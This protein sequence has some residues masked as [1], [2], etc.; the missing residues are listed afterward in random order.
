LGVETDLSSIMELGTS[1]LPS[2]WSSWGDSTVYAE[3]RFFSLARMPS[4]TDSYDYRLRDHTIHRVLL[5]AGLVFLL[6][7]GSSV[8]LLLSNSFRTTKIV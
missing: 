8:N 7:K 6:M 4:R 1:L 5:L 3:V 2:S